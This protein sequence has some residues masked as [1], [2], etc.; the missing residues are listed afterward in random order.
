M[1]NYC[2]IINN[3]VQGVQGVQGKK[4]TSL[5]SLKPS[6]GAALRGSVQ[7]VQPIPSRACARTPARTCAHTRTHLY[8][9]HTLH[10]LH[11]PRVARVA[12]VQGI[13]ARL[14]TLHKS[15][16]FQKMEKIICGEDNAKAFNAALR[17]RLPLFHDLAKQLYAHGL[18]DGLSGATLE[19]TSQ[20]K[21]QSLVAQTGASLGQI[22]R[23]C[24][25][26]QPDTVGDGT[27]VGQCGIDAQPTKLKWPQQVACDQYNFKMVDLF[28]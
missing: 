22:C 8:P 3:A 2:Q 4:L 5:H 25:H 28:K 12:R 21:V 15:I 13:R 20:A 23:D 11:S 17:Q 7:G 18:I 24:Q 14:H 19:T 16:T 27:G 6:N 26:W 1:P 9:L 10:T